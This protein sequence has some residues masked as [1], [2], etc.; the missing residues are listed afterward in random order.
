MHR[1]RVIVLIFC[2]IITVF[3]S[4][5]CT[6]A[7]RFPEIFGASDGFEAVELRIV[8]ASVENRPIECIILGRGDDV[9]F[10]LAAIHGDEPAGTKLVS[11]LSE[12]LRQKPELLIGRKV[13][14]LPVANPDGMTHNSRHNARGVDL[15]R[16]FSTANRLNDSVCGYRPLSEPEACVIEQLIREHQPARI[17][18]IHQPFACIDYDLPRR[19]RGT[20]GGPAEALVIRMSELSGLSVKKLG[21]KSGSL[22]SYAGLELGIPIITLE[23]KEDDHMLTLQALWEQYGAA[24]IAAILYPESI[25]RMAK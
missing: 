15:N 23:L 4:V 2:I 21:A 12:Y 20:A 17:V 6:E 14:L 1:K 8:G 18:S 5:G 13:V 19:A 24:L 11:E 3:L 9:T 22:G 10:I 7:V 16:N 25:K